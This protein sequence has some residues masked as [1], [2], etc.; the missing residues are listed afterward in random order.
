MTKKKVVP[1]KRYRVTT[2]IEH[3]TEGWRFE[4]GDIVTE[5]DI[6]KAPIPWWVTKGTLEVESGNW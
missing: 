5:K 4:A 3:D 2:G 1:V 6:P